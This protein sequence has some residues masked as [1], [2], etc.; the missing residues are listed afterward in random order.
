MVT[1]ELLDLGRFDR[2]LS[3]V[4]SLATDGSTAEASDAY[5]TREPAGVI[6]E[7]LAETL[8]MVQLFDA[9]EVLAHIDYP[10]RYWPYDVMP[11]DPGGF[12]EEYRVVLR[13]LAGSGKV[14]ELNTRVPMP[15]QILR[16]WYEEG[17]Q[18]I[19]FASDAHDPDSLAR[20][21]ADAAAM[22][23]ACGFRSGRHPYDQ[24]RRD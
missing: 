24:W 21:F 13:E 1:A 8:R 23:A 18:H 11:F 2:V 12:E 5:L 22:A 4:H 14:L 3:S 19:T 10:L 17:G 7:Y 16:W 9:F 6:R 20:G 15:R